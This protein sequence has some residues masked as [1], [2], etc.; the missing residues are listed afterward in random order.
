[1][2]YYYF[3]GTE[4]KNFIDRVKLKNAHYGNVVAPVIC[5]DKFFVT[6]V[7]YSNNSFVSRYVILCICKDMFTI[8]I[9]QNGSIS[10]LQVCKNC[11][12][13]C[14]WPVQTQ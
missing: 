8:L 13:G 5:G 10:N 4:I 9:T 12:C 1:M 2:K 6:R 3:C 11:S 7:N 14:K